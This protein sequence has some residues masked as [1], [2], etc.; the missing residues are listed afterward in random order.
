MESKHGDSQRQHVERIVQSAK[1]AVANAA[2]QQQ[3]SSAT[4]GK[5]GAARPVNALPPSSRRRSQVLVQRGSSGGVLIE[6]S[7]SKHGSGGDD[8]GDDGPGVGDSVGLGAGRPAN[9][10]LPPPGKPRRTALVIES[11]VLA[12][13]AVHNKRKVQKGMGQR[14]GSSGARM[15]AMAAMAAASDGDDATAHN[16]G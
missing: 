9:A 2:T 16:D 8:D 6:S 3:L 1:L 12:E 7:D 5:P 15:A 13:D 11:T 4:S 10:P 14:A